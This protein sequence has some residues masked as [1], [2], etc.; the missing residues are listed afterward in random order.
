MKYSDLA[1]PTMRP[2][3]SAE[4]ALEFFGCQPESDVDLAVLVKPDTAVEQNG[5]LQTSWQ[6][7]SAKHPTL[8]LNHL[9]SEKA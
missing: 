9:I 1:F 3:E 4:V 5:R 2:R 8:L 6:Q 7:F